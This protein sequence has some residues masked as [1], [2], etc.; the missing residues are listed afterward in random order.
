M[1][2]TD[3]PVPDDAAPVRITGIPTELADH[4]AV[5]KI[6]R[7]VLSI[8]ARQLEDGDS[9]AAESPSGAGHD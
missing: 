8:A 9:E 6:A 1:T 2:D 4:P 7:A 5:R 3:T